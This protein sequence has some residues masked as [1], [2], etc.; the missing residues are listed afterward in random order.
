MSLFDWGTI[1]KRSAALVMATGVLVAC[2]ATQTEEVET[3]EA[4]QTRRSACAVSGEDG[5]GFE[6][7]NYRAQDIGCGF[8]QD[9][10][11][12][13][14]QFFNGFLMKGRIL[15]AYNWLEANDSKV[16]ASLGAPSG[17]EVHYTDESVRSNPAEWIRREAWYSPFNTGGKMQFQWEASAGTCG[18]FN[19]QDGYL[20]VY[21]KKRA[22][23]CTAKC[24]ANGGP[25]GARYVVG[26]STSNCSEA[27]QNA[28]ANVP[29]GEYPRH[30]SCSDTDGFRGTGTQCENHVR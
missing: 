29:Q 15:C 22:Y 2:A 20:K 1:L 21:A 8:G 26:T 7:I 9:G 23:S 12:V 6:W 25:Q 3:S 30:C 27:T 17:D 18:G 14:G 5:A 28:K 24:Q 16:F 13:G 4:A 10:P 19:A 11:F